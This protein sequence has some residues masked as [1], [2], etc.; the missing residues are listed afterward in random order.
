MTMFEIIDQWTKIIPGFMLIFSR[1][2]AIVISLPIISYP[3]ISQK[4]RTLLAFVLTMILFPMVDFSTLELDT[5]S[6]LGL[7]LGREIMIGLFIG[8]GARIIFESFTM[9]GSF[10][11]RQIGIGIANVMDPT[12]RQQ[13]PV[14]SQFWALLMV[15]Y[16][17]VADG[18]YLL[19]STLF[20]NFTIIPLAGGVFTPALGERIIVS[21]S[22]AFMLALKLALPAMAFLLL[23]DT[24]IA[25]IA[26][27]M[28]QMNIF[29][30]SLPLKIGTGIIVLII[31]VDIFQLLFDV[32]YGDIA[33]Y[34]QA[35]MSE[36]KGA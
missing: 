12:S 7:A 21:G 28:P 33:T 16:F 4:I 31:S 29:W 27:V 30:V 34:I 15:T 18:H 5:L 14:I 20:K 24:A 13:I 23:V 10:V 25:F 11:G 22:R 17:L 19:I 9:A 32:V 1:L 26:R 3:I 6:G 36:L 2:S 8:F 35:I